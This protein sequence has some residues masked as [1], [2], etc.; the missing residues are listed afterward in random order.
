MSRCAVLALCVLAFGSRAAA[1]DGANARYRELLDGIEA[2]P[3]RAPIEVNSSE[4]NDQV[5]AQAWGVLDAPYAHVAEIAGRPAS[6]CDFVSLVIFVKACT[7][8]AD[9]APTTVTLYIGRKDYEDPD[10]DNAL[11]FAFT[12][13]SPGDGHINVGLFV[14]EGLLGVKDN[15]LE[16]ELWS[17]DGRTLVNVRTSYVA[18]TQS[19]LATGTYLMTFGRNKIGFSTTTDANGKAQPVKGVRGIIERNTMR[20]FL[21]LRSYLETLDVTPEQR[22]AAR[23]ERWFDATAQYE[24][25]YE[26]PREE[27]IAN[28]ARE[29]KNQAELQRAG[30]GNAN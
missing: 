22:D 4:E 2:N 20:Y 10:P 9:V 24:R 26:V 3:L 8:A 21:A 1:G 14:A 13:E 28:K 27:Y 11:A 17:V 30:P 16:F 6:F 5:S 15:R 7:F 19:K 25:L 12:N 29:R 18:S 23:I